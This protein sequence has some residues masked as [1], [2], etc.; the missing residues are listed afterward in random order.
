MKNLVALLAV[1]FLFALTACSDVN[2][3]SFLT[4]PVMEKTSTSSGIITPSPVYP[5]PYL[6]S[7]A[8]VEGIKYL[9]SE[10][11]NAIDFYIPEGKVKL[12][13]LYVVV[14]YLQGNGLPTAPKMFFINQI[15]ETNFKVEGIRAD[16][17]EKL[18]VYG[19]AA[20][21]NI[22][23]VVYPFEN[24]SAMNDVDVNGWK[25]DNRDVRIECSGTW[26]SSL[27]YV[28]AEIK[29]N[30]GSSLVFL[31][32]PYSTTFVIPGYGKYGVKEIKLFGYQ[33]VMEATVAQ[34]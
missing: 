14:N 24:N 4:N 3:N 20:N 6:F 8:E 30:T 16:Q 18:S 31:Q 1:L 17:V 7:F 13:H 29:T 15:S 10:D 27:K 2:D 28:F 33:T 26:P 34:F 32:R 21:S 25:L 23:P 11:E 9:T 5:Y 22:T 19:F 12:A